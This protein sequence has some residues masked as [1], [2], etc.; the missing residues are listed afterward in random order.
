MAKPVFTQSNIV[1]ALIVE[2][3]GIAFLTLLAGTNDDLG[4]VIVV[5]MAGLWLLFLFN[6]EG[7][8]SYI[9]NVMSNAKGALNG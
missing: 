6:H 3:V 1:L 8:Q 2:S 5:F 7:V 9:T 4:S